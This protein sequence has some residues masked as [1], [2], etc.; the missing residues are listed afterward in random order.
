MK[1]KALLIDIG[2]TIA[3]FM[4]AAALLGITNYRNNQLGTEL[5][6]QQLTT[7]LSSTDLDLADTVHLFRSADEASAIFPDFAPRINWDKQLLLTYIGSPQP[8]SGYTMKVIDARR[9]GPVATIR[10]RIAPPSNNSLNLT[11]LTQPVMVAAFNRD[12]LIASS[13]F[14]F[15]FQDIDTGRTNSLSLFLQ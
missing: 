1:S 9:Q 4:I 12:D 15:R 11:V 14:T 3:V 6:Y 5:P 7:G 10:Y 2:I 13:Q 8:T